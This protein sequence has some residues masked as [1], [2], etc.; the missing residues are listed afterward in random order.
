MPSRLRPPTTSVDVHSPTVNDA[1]PTTVTTRAIQPADLATLL[2]M[3]NA[4]VPNVNQLDQDELA[5]LVGFAEVAEA[6]LVDD[7]TKGFVLGLRPGTGYAS[8]HYRWFTDRYDDFLYVDRI[9]VGAGSRSA[10]LGTALYGVVLNHARQAAVP[11]VTCEVN[12]V[13]PNPGSLR[14]HRGLGFSEVCRRHY[15]NDEKMVTMLVRAV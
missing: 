15:D 8:R 5:E 1:S 13:P 14:F 10:G 7:V 6:V 9:V 3:N 11:R 4:A 2:A 12:L